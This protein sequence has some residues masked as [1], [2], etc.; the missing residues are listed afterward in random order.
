[1]R[2]PRYDIFFGVPGDSNVLWKESAAGLGAAD[3]KMRELAAKTPGSYF[4]FDALN[5]EIIAKMDNSGRKN[6]ERETG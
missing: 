2:V 6:E 1:M 4:I 5:S 3:E